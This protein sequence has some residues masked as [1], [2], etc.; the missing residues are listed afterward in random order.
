MDTERKP[1]VVPDLKR[2]L[3]NYCTQKSEGEVAPNLLHILRNT[4]RF[5]TLPYSTKLKNALGGLS[6]KVDAN[7]N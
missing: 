5:Q 1:R 3:N 7:P 4:Q 2:S 6:F